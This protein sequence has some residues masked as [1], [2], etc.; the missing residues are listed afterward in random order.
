MQQ[1]HVGRLES[2]PPNLEGK[3]QVTIRELLRNALRMRPNR[4]VVGECRG[5]EALDMLQAMNTGHEGSMTTL[6]SNTPRN[7]LSRLE[8]MILMSQLELPLRVCASKSP[9]PLTSLS[10]SNGFRGDP[11][12]S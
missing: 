7:A 10:R 6:H 4:I 12:A 11:G 2:R 8:T 1:R 5:A 9:L 3:G